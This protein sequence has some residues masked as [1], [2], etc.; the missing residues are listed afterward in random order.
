MEDQDAFKTAS[1]YILSDNLE[2]FKRRYND[3]KDIDS[4]KDKNGQNLL[5]FACQHNRKEFI[6]YLVENKLIDINHV[7]KQKKNCLFYIRQDET[8]TIYFLVENG[9]DVFQS[10]IVRLLCRDI[11]SLKIKYS[12]KKTKNPDI[13]FSTM[14]NYGKTLGVYQHWFIYTYLI[15]YINGEETYI[16]FM[17]KS[18]KNLLDYEHKIFENILETI[19]YI[20]KNIELQLRVFKDHE[21]FDTTEEYKTQLKNYLEQGFNF[22]K[23]KINNTKYIKLIKSLLAKECKD[24]ECYKKSVEIII[25]TY[26]KYIYI[27]KEVRDSVNIIIEARRKYYERIEI[28]K[29]LLLE[30]EKENEKNKKKPKHICKDKICDEI[31]IQATKEEIRQDFVKFT[32]D[33]EI[34]LKWNNNIEEIKDIRQKFFNED[35]EMP[36]FTREELQDKLSS[37]ERKIYQFIVFK[38]IKNYLIYVISQIDKNKKNTFKLILYGGGCIEYYSKGMRKTNDLDFKMYPRAGNIP[39]QNTLD[40]QLMFLESFV[41]PYISNRTVNLV[42]ILNG[43]CEDSTRFFKSW[44]DK[45][46]KEYDNFRFKYIYDSSRGIV[47]ISVN[48][49]NKITRKEMDIPIIDISMYKD[50]TKLIPSTEIK[51]AKSSSVFLLEKETLKDIY[52]SYIDEYVKL[53]ADAIKEDELVY[54]KP[55]SGIPVIDTVKFVG[56][57]AKE[58]LRALE[59]SEKKTD[60]KKRRSVKR[61]SVKRR[62][63]KRRSVKRRSRRKF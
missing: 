53:I 59:M 57:K 62:S 32:D 60:G 51:L 24:I 6:K 37:S 33:L 63:V 39:E 22:F 27:L 12:D 56:E 1:Q 23:L 43:D 61:R 16:D 41:L 55:V 13:I 29:S 7:D 31:S 5:M 21:G 11:Q 48:A 49:V 3:R 20:I 46:L 18:Y 15:K 26:E 54:I 50:Q 52:N 14:E 58:Q 40:K 4:I 10:N 44:K 38:Y 34:T 28:K 9:V 19:E 35:R 45:L 25:K 17:N 8:S 30:E 47:K 36:F 42:E 2:E